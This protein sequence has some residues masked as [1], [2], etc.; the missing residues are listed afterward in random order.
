M[1]RDLGTVIVC[2]ALRM[3]LKYSDLINGRGVQLL[4]GLLSDFVLPLFAVSTISL[5]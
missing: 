1:W 4:E 5:F 2:Q 3:K